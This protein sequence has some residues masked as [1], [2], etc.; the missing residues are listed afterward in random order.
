MNCRQENRISNKNKRFRQFVLQWRFMCTALKRL[1]Q[2]EGYFRCTWIELNKRRPNGQMLISSVQKRDCSTKSIKW[3]VLNSTFSIND[4]NI[5]S[6]NY[7]RKL[8]LKWFVPE[9]HLWKILLTWKLIQRTRIMARQTWLPTAVWNFKSVYPMVR[10][11][12]PPGVSLIWTVLRICYR[13]R[14]LISLRMSRWVLIKNCPSTWSKL[15][16]KGRQLV[17]RI[18]GNPSNSVYYILTIQWCIRWAICQ[19]RF[20][21]WV[22]VTTSP[23]IFL[24]G[25]ISAMWK[26]HMDLQTHTVTLNRCSSKMTGVLVLTI[27]RRHCLILPSK[28]ST[29]LTRHKFSTDYPLPMNSEILPEPTFYASSIVR[30]SH[31]SAPDLNLYSIWEK[32]TSVVSV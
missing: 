10:L 23:V 12:P 9:A 2:S 32:R 5:I 28:A 22:P 13:A 14:F 30:K 25:F 26:R 27:C 21:E 20:G 11:K 1:Q 6:D 18:C 4:S 19:C 16:P 31:F 7:G 3:H 17:F 15:K 29:I 24:N 8:G